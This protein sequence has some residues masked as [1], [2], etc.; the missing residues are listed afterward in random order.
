NDEARRY[1]QE[2][3]EMLEQVIEQQQQAKAT[4]PITASE[5]LTRTAL[6]MVGDPLE[7]GRCHELLGIV[8]ATLGQYNE[9]LEHLN[10]A[11]SIF[12]RHDQVIVLTMVYVNLGAVYATKTEYDVA[13]MF[14]QRALGMA[15]R[16]NDLANMTFVTGN[17]GDVA[18]RCGN[19]SEA[20]EW[21]GQSLAV[22]VHRALAL[23]GL[24]IEVAV[25]GQLSLASAHFLLGGTEHAQHMALQS[26]HAAREHELTRVI[27][28]TQRL[29]GRILA[30]QGQSAQADAYF[31]QA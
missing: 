31:E 14:Y 16:N 29:L 9:A 1:G 2:A 3:L 18:E 23:E 15:R 27:A 20:E 10:R 13:R 5:L 30:L 7:L 25:E 21:L 19:L 28:R 26:L 17:L 11:L 8:A 24:N 4:P 12:E 6:E 22:A